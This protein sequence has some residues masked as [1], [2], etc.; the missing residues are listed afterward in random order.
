MIESRFL[1][2]AVSCAHCKAAIEG[3]VAQLEGVEAVNVDIAG[4]QVAVR[5]DGDRVGRESIVAAIEG[6]GY[7]VSE[8]SRS[9]P[10][11]A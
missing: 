6:A 1:V 8:P 4:K 2:P 9:A 3:A 11:E 10:A 5:F 7:E